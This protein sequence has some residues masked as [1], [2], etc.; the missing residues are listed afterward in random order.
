[1]KKSKVCL[2]SKIRNKEKLMV[3]DKITKLMHNTNCF[4]GMGV[5]LRAQACQA[6]NLTTCTNPIALFSLG[7]FEI[8]F[9]F[10]SRLT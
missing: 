2:K 8:G 6:S 10:M 7:I 9:C 1:M 5:E 4:D 3:R